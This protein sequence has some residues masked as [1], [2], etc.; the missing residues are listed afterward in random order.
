[1][2]PGVYTD[3]IVNMN[4]PSNAV[5]VSKHT[6]DVCPSNLR[7]AFLSIRHLQ[8]WVL[9]PHGHLERF[10]ELSNILAASQ[11]IGQCTVK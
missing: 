5:L 10:S 4:P 8:I 7:V 11:V 3:N 6:A 9:V 1:M 2:A